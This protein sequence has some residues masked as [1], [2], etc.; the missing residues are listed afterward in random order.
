MDDEQEWAELAKKARKS[1]DRDMATKEQLEQQ[2]DMIE[3]MLKTVINQAQVA[4]HALRQLRLQINQIEEK[5]KDQ[6]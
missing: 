1:W 2:V 3:Q 5:E 4:M 6:S